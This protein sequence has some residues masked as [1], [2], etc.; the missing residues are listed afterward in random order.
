MGRNNAKANKKQKKQ[1]SGKLLYQRPR[2]GASPVPSHFV[3]QMSYFSVKTLTEAAASAGAYYTFSMTNTF[4]PDFSGAGQQ[5]VS[6]D[7]WSQMYSRFRVIRTDVQ[8]DW[9]NASDSAGVCTYFLSSTGTMPASPDA[10]ASQRAGDYGIVG[11][12]YSGK[13]IMSKKFTVLPWEG[14][15][16][17]KAQYMD[18]MDY[19]HSST[20]GPSRPL[21]TT[22]TLQGITGV[23]SMQL[24]VRLVYHVE[25]SEPVNMTVS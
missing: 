19:S 18:D 25:L 24:C 4:D 6:F 2:T 16:L 21:Y 7:Q 20:S 1:G 15:S 5:P 17:T 10:W 9:S 11:T 12:R 8:A 23:L 22:F 13:P 14:L 3:T